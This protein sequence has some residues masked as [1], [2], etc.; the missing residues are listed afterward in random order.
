MAV[1]EV[2]DQRPDLPVDVVKGPAALVTGAGSPYLI[3]PTGTTG[4]SSKGPMTR[5]CC[6]RPLRSIRLPALLGRGREPLAL[7]FGGLT[8]CLRFQPQPLGFGGV[9]LGL[10]GFLLGLL[11]LGLGL[12]CLGLG[13]LAG[14][15]L[16]LAQPL[17]FHCLILGLPARLLLGCQFGLELGDPGFVVRSHHTP[18]GPSARSHKG[19]LSEVWIA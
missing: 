17:G 8:R 10:Y 11:C 19:Q 16:L 18:R 15:L 3:A 14:S 5:D 13:L 6:P 9:C 1:S 7:R 4:S 2:V 12:L